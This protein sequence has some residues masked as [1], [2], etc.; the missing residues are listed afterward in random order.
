[1]PIIKP[2][3]VNKKVEEQQSWANT[4]TK[5]VYH[6]SVQQETTIVKSGTLSLSLSRYLYNVTHL[7]LAEKKLMYMA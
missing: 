2:K 4:Y 1:M 6:G 3:I 7:E 5:A